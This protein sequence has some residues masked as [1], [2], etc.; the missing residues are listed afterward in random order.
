MAPYRRSMLGMML[1]ITLVLSII[2]F[3]QEEGSFNLLSTSNI[4]ETYMRFVRNDTIVSVVIPF[5]Q[6]I[7][8]LLNAVDSVRNQTLKRWEMIVVLDDLGK[9]RGYCG[10]TKRQAQMLIDQGRR[11]EETSGQVRVIATS[12]CET[13]C[14]RRPYAPGFPRNFGIKH[15]S[16]ESQYIAFMDDDDCMLPNRLE[17]QVQAMEE[18]R[19]ISLCCSNG[20]HI[21]VSK[22]YT[23]RFDRY[24]KFHPLQ[25]DKEN[26]E[27]LGFPI[28]YSRYPKLYVLEKTWE[29]P[30]ISSS[31]LIRK[32]AVLNSGIA[33][34]NLRGSFD[35]PPFW[36][37][38]D[39][40][41][42]VANSTPGHLVLYLP[43]ALIAYDSAHGRP[44]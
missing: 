1:V 20:Y 22:Q 26:L 34:D 11:P 3:T 19:N 37:D 41:L 7:M 36:E 44:G 43:D 25:C 13:D 14:D 29:N 4:F 38:W 30:I 16:P 27:K 40:W 35:N 6:R 39:Y 12:E 10:I 18:N 31:A 28:W 5:C 33:W 23:N 32:E 15:A 9:L 2:R 8:P 42:R 21:R 17:L 24:G